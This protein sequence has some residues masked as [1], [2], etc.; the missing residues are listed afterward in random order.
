MAF[1]QKLINVAFTL[2]TGQFSGGGNTASLEGLRISARI[3]GPG[4]L[5][6]QTASVAIWGMPLSMM[7]QLSLIGNQYLTVAPQNT[8]S[9]TAGDSSSNMQLTFSGTIMSAFVDASS[10]PQVCFR[11]EAF[12]GGALNVQPTDASG[13]A[14]QIDVAQKMQ[15]LA[16]L[17]NPKLEFENHGVSVT[18][19][20]QYLSG[21]VGN[22]I[23]ALAQAAGIE[24]MIDRGQLSIWKS[25]Q[26]PDS[27]VTIASPDMVGHPAFSQS[28]IYAKTLFN[29]AFRLGQIVTVQSEIQAACG[30]WQ[31]N[32]VTHDIESNIPKG[33]WFTTLCGT[34]FSA[35]TASN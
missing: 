16:S 24:A 5:T 1:T 4:G 18:L 21:S 32:R 34:P 3:D 20:K 11:V 15:A 2:A 33:K 6:C 13:T 29:P 30:K 14:D 23:Y 19:R 28:Y 27:G 26:G 17:A 31:I 9:V 12:P 25:G 22:Q 10:Q 7:N 8:I 35:Q